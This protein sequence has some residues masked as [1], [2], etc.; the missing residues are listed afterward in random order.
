MNRVDANGHLDVLPT[1]LLLAVM[2]HLDVGALARMAGACRA[3]AV[4]AKTPHLWRALYMRDFGIASPPYECQ[5]CARYGKSPLWLYMV[6]ASER[7]PDR[8]LYHIGSRCL[9]GRLR[10]DD[11]KQV[12]AGDF[13]MVIQPNGAGQAVLHGYGSCIEYDQ[14][15]P[16]RADARTM[17]RRVPKQGATIYEGIW[18]MGSFVGPGR[19]HTDQH[20]TYA[21]TFVDRQAVGRVSQMST[22][23]HSCYVG[24]MEAGK[25]QGLGTYTWDN[26]SNWS[27]GERLDDKPCGRFIIHRANAQVV[28]YSGHRRDALRTRYGVRR[29][30]DGTLDECLRS[31]QGQLMYCIKRPGRAAS[32]SVSTRTT[33]DGHARPLLQTNLYRDGGSVVTAY[34]DR[35]GREPET[36][37]DATTNDGVIVG[38]L[39]KLLL[40]SLSDHVTD[41]RLAGRHFLGYGDDDRASGGGGEWTTPSTTLQD[42]CGEIPADPTSHE[43]RAFALYLVSPYCIHFPAIVK[44]LSDAVA[45]A[46]GR[47][48]VSLQWSKEDDKINDARLARTPL[49]AVYGERLATDPHPG[50]GSGDVADEQSPADRDGTR[51]GTPLH[52][53]A[54]SHRG[55]FSGGFAVRC[56]IMGGPLVPIDS[57]A[58]LSSGRLYS[59]RGI[60]RWLRLGGTHARAD[61]LTGETLP[62]PRLVLDWCPWMAAV[63][64]RKLVGVVRDVCQDEALWRNRRHP[65]SDANNG[66]DAV[67]EH[68]VS[69][70]KIV[71]LERVRVRVAQLTGAYDDRQTL[72]FDDMAAALWDDHSDGH[73][74]N[75]V[76]DNDRQSAWDT[77]INPVGAIERDAPLVRG[78]DGLTIRRVE[79][80][81]PLWEPRGPW[82]LGTPTEPLPVDD[83]REEYECEGGDG[84]GRRPLRYLRSHGMIRAA[85]A[86]PTFAGARLWGVYFIGH[87]FCGASFVG[88]RFDRCVFIGCRFERCLCAD[89]LWTECA[90]YDCQCVSGANG[91]TDSATAAATTTNVP[92]PLTSECEVMQ[93]VLANRGVL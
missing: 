89:A 36:R 90:F 23:D 52:A 54:P 7:H 26:A 93:R 16:E 57:C 12:R 85:L 41:R 2:G 33:F 9:V 17:R 73:H 60:E 83:T 80:R 35:N 62:L 55:T 86:S 40:L 29:Y 27:V 18:K 28:T 34:R 49:G 32:D 25:Y 67:D 74:E 3:F 79:W 75:T 59:R 69:L 63:G 6:A 51:T 56:F 44:R 37:F 8:L 4:A 64:A 43:A 24:P 76:S 21:D 39:G 22:I 10:T 38:A 48:G 81:H 15:Q 47:A 45:V 46:A 84:E 65:G 14:T 78:L 71:I 77:M 91:G 11:G 53:A 88:A 58:L 72:V 1:E 20:V 82:R 92:I 13:Y 61:P 31:D 50:E 19:I 30:W 5:D 70:W 87:R 68:T 42:V 66:V